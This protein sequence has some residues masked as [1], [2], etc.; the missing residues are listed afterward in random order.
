MLSHSEQMLP[1]LRQ[2]VAGLNMQITE[3]Q[4]SLIARYDDYVYQYNQ[5]TNLTRIIDPLEVAVK[6]F[7]D[8]FLLCRQECLFFG[9]ALADIGSGAGFPGIPLAI[10]RPDIHVTLVDSLR[11]RTLFLADVVQELGLSN[12][13]VCWG[14]V[15]DLAQ[16]TNY[17]E[18]FDVVVAR[19]VA[20]LNVLAELCLPLVK[21]WGS[22]LAMK[23]PRGEAELDRAAKAI[24]LMGGTLVSIA[25]NCLPMLAEKRSIIRIDKVSSTPRLYPRKPGIPEKQPL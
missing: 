23:G 20:P 24:K 14:R 7:G 16:R 2:V 1:F 10:V 13:Q 5:M 19:A 25:N 22:F 11:K 6:H 21:V 17:R 9:C 15:E 18:S 12:V 4:F 3:D 8:S